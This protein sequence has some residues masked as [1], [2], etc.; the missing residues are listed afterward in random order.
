MAHAQSLADSI[1]RCADR[2][3]VHLRVASHAL[4]GAS[5]KESEAVGRLLQQ[6]KR[7]CSEHDLRER[8]DR[9]RGGSDAPV[10]DGDAFG[11]PSWASSGDAAAAVV[12]AGGA[13]AAAAV[14][15]AT[16]DRWGAATAAAEM[17]TVVA[18]VN[19][20][21][22]SRRVMSSPRRPPPL[23]TTSPASHIATKRTTAAA[24]A[25]AAAATKTTAAAVAEAGTA[26]AL[27][28]PAAGES[29]AAPTK[30]R[31][32]RQQQQQQRQGRRQQQ[33]QQ[34]QQHAYGHNSPAERHYAAT[35]EEL[36]ARRSVLRRLHVRRADPTVRA[37]RIWPEGVEFSA[38]KDDSSR[39]TGALEGLEFAAKLYATPRLAAHVPRGALT[40]MTAPAEAAR[41]SHVAGALAALCANAELGR[42]GCAPSARRMASAATPWLGHAGELAALQRRVLGLA[43]ALSEPGLARF[44]PRDRSGGSGG[45]GGGAG[46]GAVAADSHVRLAAR[47]V[48]LPSSAGV[49]DA[50]SATLRR[51][52]V[53]AALAEQGQLGRA[54]LLLPELLAGPDGTQYAE[55]LAA[56]RASP[57]PGDNTPQP[58][59]PPRF[60]RP[61]RG[62][63]GG[64][65]MSGAAAL[66]TLAKDTLPAHCSASHWK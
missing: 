28:R 49:A 53:L 60:R 57:R 50:I 9:L 59:V 46:S 34:Q 62:R 31:Q 66:A 23:V 12:G 29:A 16:D 36:T 35:L 1:A 56:G 51:A 20:K 58:P 11:A 2:A 65:S 19:P 64:Q 33:Q 44:F 18:A 41:L 6:I 24:V 37:C 21:S 8:R 45:G 26:G 22:I 61:N 13:A 17:A 7:L 15:A 5:A 54:E 55:Q 63:A 10:C 32:R 42:L 39:M 48:T 14:A 4:I 40:M 52:R 38:E 47:A 3:Q 43:K 25:A 30:P 27:A